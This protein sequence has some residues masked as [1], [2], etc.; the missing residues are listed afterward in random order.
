MNHDA[1]VALMET[2][3]ESWNAG[4]TNRALDCFADDAV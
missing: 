3:A 4:D 1:F 2:I